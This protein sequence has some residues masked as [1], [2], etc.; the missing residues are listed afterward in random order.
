MIAFLLFWITKKK[1]DGTLSTLSWL[2]QWD[3]TV[4]LWRRYC[5]TNP[6][7][8]SAGL[9]AFGLMDRV[10]WIV[11]EF[12][13][14]NQYGSDLRM[15]FFVN[16]NTILQFFFFYFKHFSFHCRPPALR[17]YWKARTCYYLFLPSF[18]YILEG[19]RP[20]STM[21]IFVWNFSRIGIC[22]LYE[23]ASVRAHG[24]PEMNISLLPWADD[25]AI[26]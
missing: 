23:V 21:I 9:H 24:M 20:T 7:F 14:F 26:R 18:M 25:A 4:L 6:A 2:F 5:Q 13:M 17:F 10:L 22:M 12:S 19:M 1:C 8:P 15:I 11:T 3:V 16:A